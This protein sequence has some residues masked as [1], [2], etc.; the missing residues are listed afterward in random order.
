MSFLGLLKVWVLQTFFPF[1]YKCVFANTVDQEVRNQAKDLLL[2]QFNREDD[3]QDDGGKSIIL[4]HRSNVVGHVKVKQQKNNRVASPSSILR[5]LKAG[6]PIYQV[7]MH[8]KVM[9]MDEEM[10]D[11]L[12]R[13]FECSSDDFQ[14]K[15]TKHDPNAVIAS[16]FIHPLYR[17][18]GFGKAMTRIGGWYAKSIGCKTI[19]GAAATESLIDFY[20]KLG[21]VSDRNG[22]T[23]RADLPK[24][25]IN[26]RGLSVDLIS[27]NEKDLVD[28]IPNRIDCSEI[29][30]IH[31]D[32]VYV[33]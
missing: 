10:V 30:N 2:G 29:F 5:K 25:A 7:R 16:L 11:K 15:D 24:V 27:L 20:A 14:I 9:N 33:G 22:H 19:V 23:A 13:Q 4:L 18:R 26:D 21:G 3:F 6:V 17:N 31:D 12:I 1:S 28:S 32:S 8:A